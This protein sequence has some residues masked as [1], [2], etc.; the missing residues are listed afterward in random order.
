MAVLPPRRRSPVDPLPVRLPSFVEQ[1]S[2]VSSPPWNYPHYT[3]TAEKHGGRGR[4]TPRRPAGQCRPWARCTRWASSC[5]KVS[6]WSGY[7]SLV[8]LKTTRFQFQ[9]CTS[10][11]GQSNGRTLKLRGSGNNCEIFL[12]IILICM[13]FEAWKFFFLFFFGYLLFFII[14]SSLSVT[15]K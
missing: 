1:L 4:L 13:I 6:Y 3:Q 15:M 5:S 10:L 2:G 7:W 12:I 14:F 11:S 9:F 8:T